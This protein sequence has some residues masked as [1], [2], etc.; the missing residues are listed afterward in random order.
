MWVFDGHVYSLKLLDISVFLSFSLAC[1]TELPAGILLV[2]IMDRL[3]RRFTGFLTMFLAA[4][5]SL[6]ELIIASGNSTIFFHTFKCF[7]T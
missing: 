7:I 2:V 5:F 3:G 6:A 4:I 1:L